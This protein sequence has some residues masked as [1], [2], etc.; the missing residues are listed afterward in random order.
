LVGEQIEP[1]LAL[2]A[3]GFG[4]ILLA[5]EDS[6]GHGETGIL[7]FVEVEVGGAL[8]TLV[9]EGVVG[10]TSIV[11]SS[12][13]ASV[14]FEVE[15]RIAFETL[16]EIV[17]GGLSLVVDL[18]SDNGVETGTGGLGFGE[19]LDQ[20]VGGALETA[21][22]SLLEGVV[23]IGETVGVEVHF[24]AEEGIVIQIGESVEVDALDAGAGV[25]VLFAI[26]GGSIHTSII[27]EVFSSVAFGAYLFGSDL[28]V[29]GGASDDGGGL[30]GVVD[31]DEIGHAGVASVGG[32]HFLGQLAVIETGEGR[33]GNAFSEEVSDISFVADGANDGLVVLSESLA[34]GVVDSGIGGDLGTGGAD[35]ETLVDQKSGISIGTFLASGGGV[36]VS[37]NEGDVQDGVI[38]VHGDTAVGALEWLESLAFISRIQSESL[39]A[40]LTHSGGVDGQT[41]VRE[42]TGHALGVVHHFVGDSEGESVETRGAS[43]HEVHRV[44][45]V[46]IGNQLALVNMEGE[47]GVENGLVSMLA[48]DAE[49]TQLGEI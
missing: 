38:S 13:F 42:G 22:T 30:T 34:V 14:V 26:L 9:G 47:S 10:G 28:G 3:G 12:G 27:E 39:L 45:D 40:E 29:V 44:G 23:R 21:H 16:Q 2:S 41:V 7:V 4:E 6:V 33:L 24:D 11:E 32:V 1:G 18:A 5:V 15:F 20:V 17:D 8:E 36:I 25:I 37:V 35:Q 48:G 46:A 31:I 19:G 43:I 49:N